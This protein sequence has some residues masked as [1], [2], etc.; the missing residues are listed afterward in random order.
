VVDDV[1]A[2][3]GT[4]CAAVELVRRTG[5]TVVGVA[6]IMDLPALGGAERVR[7]LGVPVRALLNGDAPV[8]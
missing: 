6:V 3:G 4:A 2:T 1:L 7:A 5:A 8:H